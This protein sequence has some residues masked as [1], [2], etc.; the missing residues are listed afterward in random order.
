MFSRSLFLFLL[1]LSSIDV[2]SAQVFTQITPADCPTSSDGLFTTGQQYVDPDNGVLQ[3]SW[4]LL[5]RW[6][7]DPTVGDTQWITNPVAYDLGIY[8]G[9]TSPASSTSWQRGYAPEDPGGT[10]GVQLH[11]SDIGML[12]NTWATPHAGASILGGGF[13][14]MYGYAWSP[15][16]LPS[17]FKTERNGS[18]VPAELVVQAEL[19]VP[20]LVGW[21]GLQQPDG[22]YA[23]SPVADST[24]VGTYG[25][26]TVA[27]FVY[28]ADTTHPLLHPIA[29]LAGTFDNGNGGCAGWAGGSKAFVGFD[30]G[31]NRSQLGVWFASSLMCNSDA[32]TVRYSA[33]TAGTPYAGQQFYRIHITPQ[34][35]VNV[36]NRIN[37]Q[38]CSPG[39]NESCGCT[40]GLTCPLVG[41][42]TNPDD[43]RVRYLGVIAEVV[44]CDTKGSGATAN[45]HCASNL[46]DASLPGYNPGQDSNL[47]FSV[48]ASGVSAFYYTDN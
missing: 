26:A 18:I 7:G 47:S 31:V 16:T 42:S 39:Q 35:L 12:I 4:S 24:A 23:Y 43:Y 21:S 38:Q 45:V 44:L 41:Y 27:F 5:A 29:I 30:Y 32:T 9:Y 25:S 1:M 14:D 37:A 36:A 33:P 22:S 6:Q 11:C 20:L 40:P 19:G 48:N 2:A 46:R 34:N 10:P 15:A 17:A 8:T 13:N 3:N 28:L